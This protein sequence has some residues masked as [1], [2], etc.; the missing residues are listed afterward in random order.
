VRARLDLVGAAVAEAGA[1]EALV[2][3]WNYPADLVDLGHKS[4][5]VSL[6]GVAKSKPSM[7]VECPEQTQNRRHLGAQRNRNRNSLM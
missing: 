7:S 1:V 6:G 4:A 5:T 3:S 2:E